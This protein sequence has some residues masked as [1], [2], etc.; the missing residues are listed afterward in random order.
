MRVKCPNCGQWIDIILPLAYDNYT[1]TAACGF[2]G[3]P[4]TVEISVKAGAIVG[5]IEVKGQGR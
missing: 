3:H 1:M 5:P 4:V 2:C